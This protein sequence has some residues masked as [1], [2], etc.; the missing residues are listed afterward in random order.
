MP[1]PD[2]NHYARIFLRALYVATALTLS[3]A[4]FS[5]MAGTI[6]RVSTSVGDYS[7]EL[8]DETAPLTVANFLGYVARNDFNGT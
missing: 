6:V 3:L 8:L 2:N 7:I 5:S 4:S 1:I